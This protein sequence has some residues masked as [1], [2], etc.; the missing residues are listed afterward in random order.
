MDVAVSQMFPSANNLSDA[1][2]AYITQNGQF[3]PDGSITVP[4]PGGWGTFNIAAP[5]EGQVTKAHQSNMTPGG[6][7]LAVVLRFRAREYPP[8]SR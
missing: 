6:T 5:I 3:N 7:L 8:P 1:W 4:T 2:N